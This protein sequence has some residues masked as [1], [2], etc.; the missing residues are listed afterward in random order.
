MPS[1]LE[2]LNLSQKKFMWHS[3]LVLMQD[4]YISGQSKLNKSSADTGWVLCLNKASVVS[5]NN[6][7]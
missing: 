5:V 2:T 4:V 6:E 3:L 7:R 1:D